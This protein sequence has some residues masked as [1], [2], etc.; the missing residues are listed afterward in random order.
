MLIN[1]FAVNE[2]GTER[3]LGRVVTDSPARAM[4]MY[5]DE[6]LEDEDDM[7]WREVEG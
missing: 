7:L 2:D 4:E 5:D 1:I 6:L 3:F